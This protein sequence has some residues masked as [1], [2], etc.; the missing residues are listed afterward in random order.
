MKTVSAAD[1]KAAVEKFAKGEREA[2]EA[3]DT[4]A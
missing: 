4:Q 1:A 3:T 2:V